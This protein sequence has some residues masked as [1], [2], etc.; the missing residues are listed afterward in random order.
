[1]KE[2]NARIRHF[3]RQSVTQCIIAQ[4][5]GVPMKRDTELP[6]LRPRPLFVLRRDADINAVREFQFELDLE[7]AESLKRW[8]Y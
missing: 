1:M 5:L 4:A 2:N 8:R 6:P 7:I 3:G